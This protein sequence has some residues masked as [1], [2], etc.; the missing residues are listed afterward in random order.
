MAKA[1]SE[2][3]WKLEKIIMYNNSIT[4]L[5]EHPD[6]MIEKYRHTL[7]TFNENQDKVCLLWR[8]HPLIKATMASMLP[9]LWEEYSQLIEEYRRADWGIYDDTP[10]LDRAIALSDGYCGD[11]SSVVKLM[12][13][14]GKV[15]MIQNADVLQ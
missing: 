10:D 6:K 15:C 11:S 1:Y 13:E 2:A 5:L 9:Q 4:A 7:K 12:Q 3:R 8:P 14:A